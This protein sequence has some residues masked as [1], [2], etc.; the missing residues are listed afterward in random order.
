MTLT[1]GSTNEYN[2]RNNT[3][4]VIRCSQWGNIDKFER[5][6]EY[7]KLIDIGLASKSG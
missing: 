7:E 3:C 5:F 4:F 1:A 6:H 2:F